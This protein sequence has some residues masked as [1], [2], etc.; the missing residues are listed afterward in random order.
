MQPPECSPPWGHMYTHILQVH[1]RQQV[2][3]YVPVPILPNLSF[4]LLLTPLTSLPQRQRLHRPQ[5]RRPRR[6]RPSRL[7]QRHHQS[8][9]PHIP[10]L[11]PRCPDHRPPTNPRNT[12]SIQHRRI[13]DP[14]QKQ[15]TTR[16]AA[17]EI[18]LVFPD[19]YSQGRTHRSIRPSKGLE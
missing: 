15:P 19:Q 7:V 5:H 13:R 3:Q 10:R 8:L 9:A 17:Q 18:K 16:P 12:P 14:R 1:G 11:R 6:H 4:A 2:S